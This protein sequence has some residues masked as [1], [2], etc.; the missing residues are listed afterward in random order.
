MLPEGRIPY[1]ENKNLPEGF[2]AITR[3][4]GDLQVSGYVEPLPTS[5]PELSRPSRTPAYS[6]NHMS[7]ACSSVKRGTFLANPV[8]LFE[9]TLIRGQPVF[10]VYRFSPSS[11]GDSSGRVQPSTA[12]REDT[13]IC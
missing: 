8:N 3:D 11:R 5:V 4:G 12:A 7:R 10:S 1:P 9:E 2:L 13:H 6:T